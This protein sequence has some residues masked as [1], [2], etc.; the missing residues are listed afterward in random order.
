MESNLLYSKYADLDV[1]LI[2]NHPLSVHMKLT[3]THTVCVIWVS[4]YYDSDDNNDIEHY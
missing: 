1:S 2:Q 3:S 4:D